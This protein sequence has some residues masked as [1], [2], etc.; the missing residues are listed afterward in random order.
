MQREVDSQPSKENEEDWLQRFC[1]FIN[2]FK[3]I[4]LCASG[5]GAVEVKFDFTEEHENLGTEAHCE[6]RI[7]Y[8]MPREKKERKGP[9][10]GVMP[11]TDPHECSLYAPK[12]GDRSDK[13]PLKQ[14]RCARRDAWDTAKSIFKPKEK[15]Q[16][17]TS[18][19]GDL[20]STSTIL[21]ETRGKR[22]CGGIRDFS[23][24]LLSRKDLNS[25]EV[26]PIRVS[27]SPTTV[28]TASGEV[29]TNEERRV[30]I[31]ALGLFVTVQILEDKRLEHS[32]KITD[33]L[34]S[35]PVVKNH[36]F[37]NDRKIQATRKIRAHRCS[38]IINRTSQLD[39]EYIFNIGAAGLKKCKNLRQAQHPYEVR[40][41]AVEHGETCCLST[42]TANK[43]RNEN[44]DAALGSRSHD[45]PERFEEFTEHLVDDQASASSDAPASIFS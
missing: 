15:E 8:I 41:H 11:R 5:C 13:E 4:R 19:R 2:E 43:N 7:R 45:L 9:S 39:F 14:E 29:Q 12:F 31:Y 24:Q 36:F 44:I 37:F 10:E 21:N 26:E 16:S 1:C 20:L 17:Y 33:T 25:A 3:L 28:I 18:T 30:Y 34:R 23:A 42:E 22:I 27:G 6:V 32:A 40:V 38:G 35:G